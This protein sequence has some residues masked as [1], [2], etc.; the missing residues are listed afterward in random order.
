MADAGLNFSLM[1]M[2]PAFKSCYNRHEYTIVKFMTVNIRSFIS[3]DTANVISLWRA[4]D[5]T[6]PWNDPNKDIQRKLKVADNLF[7]V[8]ESG[9]QIVGSVMGGY[10]GHRGWINYLAV[11]PSHR[12]LG[13]GRSLMLEVEKRLLEQG[14][15]KINLQVR[16]TNTAVIDFYESIG[17]SD[18]EVR[19][20]GKRLIPD[21]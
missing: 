10:D 6:R 20:F 14:C 9:A 4:C 13:L 5:L 15:P 11:D 8:A 12:K 21:N 16:A 18:D 2:S 19:S 3:Q 7:L 1:V 17:F